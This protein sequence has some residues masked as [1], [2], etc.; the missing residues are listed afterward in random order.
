MPMPGGSAYG[1]GDPHGS[2]G[3]SPHGG[4]MSSTE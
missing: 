3:G 4:A 1:G 2:G